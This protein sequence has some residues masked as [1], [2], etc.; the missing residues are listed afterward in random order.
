MLSF[1][2]HVSY[3]SSPTY[4]CRHIIPTHAGISGWSLFIS[5]IRIAS[6]IVLKLSQLV[7]QIQKRCNLG[8]H[9]NKINHSIHAIPYLQEREW[10]EWWYK[11]IEIGKNR[12]TLSMK[13]L[14][15][16]IITLKSSE[17]HSLACAT[18]TWMR[19]AEEGQILNHRKYQCIKESKEKARS[20]RTCEH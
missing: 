18:L 6:H 10:C 4:S 11:E 9:K 2:T 5:W 13:M 15:R 8:A 7:A 12:L 17:S 14:S 20:T 19:G 16:E 1:N 3:N